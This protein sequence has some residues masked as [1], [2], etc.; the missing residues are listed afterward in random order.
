MIATSSSNQPSKE[1]VKES[2]QA[3]KVDQ[4]SKE[5][6]VSWRSTSSGGVAEKREKVVGC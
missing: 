6:K 2:L 3:S 5:M 1:D 4:P